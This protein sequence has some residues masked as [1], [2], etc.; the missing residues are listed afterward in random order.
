M[1]RGQFTHHG[2]QSDKIVGDLR[3]RLINALQQRGLGGSVYAAGLVRSM[4]HAQEGVQQRRNIKA[5]G[6]PGV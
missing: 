1:T 5:V 4:G 2:F 6:P 3:F